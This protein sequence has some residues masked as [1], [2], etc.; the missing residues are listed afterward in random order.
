[1]AYLDPASNPGSKPQRFSVKNCKSS[2]SKKLQTFKT[3]FGISCKLLT[4]LRK[5]SS[6]TAATLGGNFIKKNH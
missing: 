1:M 6:A 2:S 3:I 4:I 5:T